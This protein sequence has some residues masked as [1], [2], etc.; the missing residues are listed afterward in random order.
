M[1]IA[2][3][4]R[5]SAKYCDCI[6]GLIIFLA[7]ITIGLSIATNNT[8]IMSKNTTDSLINKSDDCVSEH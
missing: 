7:A 4:S 2:F 8:R 5:T 3:T 6:L 1:L